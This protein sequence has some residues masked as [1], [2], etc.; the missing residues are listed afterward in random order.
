M[1]AP[2]QTQNSARAIFGYYIRYEVLNK[3][4]EDANKPLDF[5]IDMS[6]IL[7]R[8]DRD[9]GD[10]PYSDPLIIASHIINMVAHYRNYFS[11]KC[12][13]RFFIIDSDSLYGEK[14]YQGFKPKDLS[15]G[16]IK[17]RDANREILPIL[18]QYI[19][20]VYYVYTSTEFSYKA[21]SLITQMKYNANNIFITKDP[22]NFQACVIQDTYVLYPKKTQ[23]DGDISKIITPYNVSGEY[24]RCIAKSDDSTVEQVNRSVPFGIVSFFM[25]IT[26]IPSR[27]LH[28][29][30]S[31]PSALNKLKRFSESYTLPIGYVWDIDPFINAFCRINEL[32]K[33]ES[34][35]RFRF[36]ACDLTT[37]YM[38]YSH[39]AEAS[40]GLDLVNLYDPNAIKDI[41][42]KYFNDYP[43]DLNAL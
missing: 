36:K 7:R 22:F 35:I 32:E 9:N 2:F 37:Q 13:T 12:L 30:Y 10:I 20:D 11:N 14:F 17:I 21:I 28:S 43:L 41:N 8:L 34:D 24:I 31:L 5:Y 25:A 29:L 26:R 4:F 15:P 23:K 16:M 33:D 19:N 42:Q 1:I 39:T 6:D 3:I 18:C 40:V 27:G 38:L